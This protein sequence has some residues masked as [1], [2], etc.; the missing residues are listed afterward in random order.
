MLPHHVSHEAAPADRGRAFGA[1]QR[2]PIAH[3]IA[4]YRRLLQESAGLDA[5]GMRA[6]GAAVAET[7]GRE[8][9]LLV[10][11]LEGMAAGAGQDARDLFAVN[12]RTELL[13]GS[14]AVECSVIGRLDGADVTLAQTWDWHPDLADSRVLWTVHHGDGAWFTTATEAGVLAKLGLNHH[15]VACALNLLTCTADGGTGGMPIHVLLRLVLQHAQDA[16]GAAELLRAAR[17]TASSAITLA[18]AGELLAVELSPGGATVLRPDAGGWLVHTN[19]FLAPPATG[20]DE[21]EQGTHLR[22][23][24]LL[25]LA[26]AGVPLEEAL[27][28]HLPD[29]EPVCRHGDGDDVAWADRIQ[30][31][32]TLR[33]DPR[34][35]SFAL[36]TGPPCSAPL[37]PVEL[38]VAAAA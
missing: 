38:P 31:L 3:T 11:E 20:A 1:A 21:A 6:A 27:A 13:A 35:P 5:T 14:K 9:P 33:L 22:R 10:D 4:T 16:A 2:D 32:L 25:E 26:R 37:E 18:S 28:S 24:R 12:A 15:G 17:V 19:H 8:A 23:D 30:T 36:A 34:A 29:E 7:L